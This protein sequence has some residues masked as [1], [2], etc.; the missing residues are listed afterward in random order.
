MIKIAM[1][2]GSLR[3]GS[4]N[5][6][7]I[8]AAARFASESLGA[9]VEVETGRLGEIP[10]YSEDTEERGWPEPVR[11]QR[12]RLAGA[13]A[14][15]I[16]TPEYNGSVPGVLKNA[17][18]WHSRPDGQGVLEGKPVATMSAS[19]SSFGA[20]WAQEDLRFVLTQ[21]GATLINDDPVVLPNALD[22]L[23]EAGELT[24]PAALR[25]VEA[26]TAMTV[27]HCAAIVRVLT[28]EDGPR[29][30]YVKSYE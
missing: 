9:A 5:S 29:R 13:D 17:L 3:E 21:C 1:L 22:A 24:E 10:P 2:S 18:D 12:D 11:A 23:D 15:L 8:R 19:S 7:A 28:H 25:A 26:L 6:A 20:A 4:A 14:L 27:D 16:S 30:R